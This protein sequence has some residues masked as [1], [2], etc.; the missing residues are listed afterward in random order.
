MGSNS[1]RIVSCEAVP[2]PTIVP[3]P[4]PA[5]SA[6]GQGGSG[7]MGQQGPPPTQEPQ[8]YVS[9][10]Y[11]CNP[12]TYEELHKKCK[13]EITLKSIIAHIRFGWGF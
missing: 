2:D 12:G 10:T 3:P 5:S 4:P 6:A 8:P 11:K 13:G 9:E 1:S 7:M